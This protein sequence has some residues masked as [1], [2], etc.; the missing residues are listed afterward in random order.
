MLF[1]LQCIYYFSPP[2]GGFR[3]IANRINGPG[4]LKFEANEDIA[5]HIHDVND[6]PY[7]AEGQLRENVLLGSNKELMIS[8]VEIVNDPDVRT[9][10]IEN[11]HCLFPRES[12]SQCEYI[13]NI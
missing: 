9:I 2:Y 4:K 11:R 6:V 3:L 10:D 7:L 12:N 8:I 13:I 1:V 5:I